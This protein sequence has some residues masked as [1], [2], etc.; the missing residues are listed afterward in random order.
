MRIG[1]IG[2]G[3]AGLSTAK[4]LRMFGYQVIVF[5]QAGD[6]GGVWSASR[7][8]PGLTTQNPRDT[9]AFSDFPMP[10]DYPEW[11]SGAQMQHYLEAYVDRFRLRGDIHLDCQ[12]VAAAALPDNAGWNLTVRRR[13]SAAR[14]DTQ[15]V[16]E[17]RTVTVD[18]LIVCNGIFSLP[19]IP[20]F[21]GAEAFA[22]A[23]GIVCHTSQ[24]TD[25]E[26][27]RGKHALVIGYGKSSC[28]V[29][30]AVAD[31]GASTTVVT[32]H[33][34]WKIPRKLGG[35]LNYKHLLL[36]RLGE[37][38]FPYIH[39]KGFEKFFHGPARAMPKSMLG[40][41]ESVVARQLK[42]HRNGLHPGTPL[43]SIARST[44][45]LV[46]DGF[47]E[48]LAAGRLAVKKSASVTRLLEGRAELST[49]ETVPADI[50]ICGTGWEQRVPFL[51]PATRARVTDARGNFRLYRSMLPLGVPRLAFNGYN[52]SFFSQLNAEI[53][54]LWLVEHL[55][56]RIT[57]PTPEARAAEIDARLAWMERRT[58]GKHAKGTN[59]IPFSVHHMDELLDDIALKLPL[60][61][62]L[63]HWLVAI[64]AADY[65]PLQK[66]LLRRHGIDAA[67]AYAPSPMEAVQWAS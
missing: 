19:S 9:Y 62:R 41:V 16:H 35:V 31:V 8:Y 22:S 65:A 66:R 57:L 32:R 37:A 34:L 13:L 12:V 4:T 27:A 26:A 48:K 49:G 14:P 24:F 40:G 47:Y 44:V 10:R 64:N 17:S 60:G 38:L 51:D 55:A 46:T 36:T 43:A 54:A 56:G 61:T 59:I 25:L 7:R 5:E 29:A 39:L 1:I 45:S 11:P 2:A 63:K 15:A 23:G 58:D 33:L 67:T 30:N 52:S 21:P 3:L 42:L 28:D 53:G 20:D 18:W 50:V 6:V